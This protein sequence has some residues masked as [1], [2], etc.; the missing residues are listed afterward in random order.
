MSGTKIMAQKTHLPPK[1]E[2]HESPTG[3]YCSSRYL[4]AR[5]C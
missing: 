1:P 4:A 2:M 5:I 3:G